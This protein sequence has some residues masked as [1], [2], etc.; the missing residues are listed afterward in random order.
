M[1]PLV[2]SLLTLSLALLWLP[3]GLFR[4]PVSPRALNLPVI[5]SLLFLAFYTQPIFFSEVLY[6]IRLRQWLVL[7]DEQRSIGLTFLFLY[8]AVFWIAYIVHVKAPR[9]EQGVVRSN[10][11]AVGLG[12]AF[13]GLVSLAVYIQSTGGLEQFL[14]NHREATYL[15][16]W[17]RSAEA[18]LVS[19]IRMITGFITITAA[20]VGGY[21]IARHEKAEPLQKLLYWSLPLPGTLIKLALLSRGFF[22]LYALFFLSRAVISQRK[23]RFFGLKIIGIGL[24]VMAGAVFSL[25]SRSGGDVFSENPAVFILFLSNSIN[26]ISAFLDT[27]AIALQ[28]NDGSIQRIFFE[29]SPIPSF[30]YSST[31]ETNLSTLILGQTSGSSTPMPFIGEA[32]YNLGWGGLVLAYLQGFMAA[33]VNSKVADRSGFDR[34]WWL[35]LYITSIYSFIYMPH[36][37]IRSCTRPL[38]WVLTLYGLVKVMRVIAPTKRQGR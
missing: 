35:L 20:V 36:S 30:I 33:L 13:I 1:T 14:T 19:R 3:N 23:A 4:M 31:Y 32:F 24:L 26:G 11:F 17:S 9:L 37:G 22:L 28:E 6:D 7:H 10:Y 12:T 5:F 29:L 34:I 25:Q 15:D 16:Q 38:V 27:F 2:F 21:L 18:L 8:F